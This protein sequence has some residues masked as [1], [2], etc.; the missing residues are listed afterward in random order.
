[1]TP[2]CGIDFKRKG[3]E[4]E[5]A[6]FLALLKAKFENDLRRTSGLKKWHSLHVVKS[7]AEGR[8]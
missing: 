6:A 7:V 8:E 4:A 3:I 1:M 5:K 2:I